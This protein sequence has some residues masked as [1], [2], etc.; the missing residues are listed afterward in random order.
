[1]TK[2]IIIS[3]IIGALLLFAILVIIYFY[4]MAFVKNK[5]SNFERIAPEFAEFKKYYAQIEDA[6]KL[7]DEAAKEE[8][9]IKSF[10]GLKLHATIIDGNFD[11]TVVLF[12]GYRSVAKF[13][14]ACLIP[15]YKSIGMNI[16]LVDHRSHG[17]SEGRLITYGVKERYD[18]RDWIKY[19]KCKFPNTKIFMHGVSMGA[20]TALMSSDMVEGVNGI[21][22]D[23][24]FTSPKAIIQRVARENMH[25][26]TWLVSPVGLW[27]RIFGRFNYAYS[28]KEALAKTTIP[29]LFIHGAKDDFV[30]PL[31]T[32]ENYEACASKKQKVIVDNATHALSYLTD[33]E[34]VENA[35]RNFILENEEG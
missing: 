10:D 15:F 1:M 23:C 24:G 17:E 32:D 18:A 25:L 19:T 16:V 29:I 21:I 3:S 5:G 27:A 26:P 6:S 12:H 2:W 4:R 22:A 34:C 33:S 20:A 28:T 9:Y 13:D 31:M 30:P 8:A 35:I 14:F 11:K 7:L